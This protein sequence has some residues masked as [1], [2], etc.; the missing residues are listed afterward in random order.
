MKRTKNMIVKES[1]ESRELLLYT[2]NTSK[3]YFNHIIP[4]I[5]NLQ[6]HYKRGNF[7]REKAIDAFYYVSDAAA[8][9]Y[10]KEFG[11][12]KDFP[13]VF[14]VTARF[15]CAACLLDNYMENI[16]NCDI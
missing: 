11:E 8:K 12:Y 4:V 16:I 10:C 15:T 1:I 6:K 14:D 5:H 7:D 3:I 9:M 13:R 2:E